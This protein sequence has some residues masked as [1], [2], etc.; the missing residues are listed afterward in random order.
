MYS[1]GPL[2]I[3]TFSSPV[4]I[5]ECAGNFSQLNQ[6][7]SGDAWT[8]TPLNWGGMEGAAYSQ[9]GFKSEGFESPRT[10]I[11]EKMFARLRGE[12]AK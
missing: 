5:R 6:G 7:R 12:P 4:S 8:V 2:K 3:G 10:K 11:M 1:N 9:T